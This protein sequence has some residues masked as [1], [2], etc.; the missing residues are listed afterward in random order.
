MSDLS[1]GRE[2]GRE[3]GRGEGGEGDLIEV[4]RVWHSSPCPPQWS[5]VPHQWTPVLVTSANDTPLNDGNNIEKNLS[6]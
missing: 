6:S 5:C 2:G 4:E 3:G 1:E